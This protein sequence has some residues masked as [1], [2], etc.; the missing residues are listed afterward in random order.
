[1]DFAITE[2]LDSFI[3]YQGNP[4]EIRGYISRLLKSHNINIFQSDNKKISFLLSLILRH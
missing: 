3:F 2:Q 4:Q 1:M